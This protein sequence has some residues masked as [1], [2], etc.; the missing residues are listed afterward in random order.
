MD[1]VNRINEVVDYTEKNL[2]KEIDTGKIS[3]IMN[4]PYP[5]FQQLF[6]QAAGIPMEE[7]IRQRKFTKAACDIL[8]SNEQIMNIALKYGYESTDTFTTAFNELHGVSPSAVRK[9]EINLK[10]YS[11][12]RFGLSINCEQ[13]NCEQ[14]AEKQGVVTTL[15]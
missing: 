4:C 2:P 13:Y 14:E 9:P 3:Q 8:N 15:K 12:L 11:R 5:V 10:L 1:L 7:Y 6:E